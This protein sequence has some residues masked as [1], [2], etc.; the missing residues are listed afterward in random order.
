M[1]DLE[2]RNYRK[3]FHPKGMSIDTIDMK[4]SFKWEKSCEYSFSEKSK[5]ITKILTKYGIE[6]E[7]IVQRLKKCLPKGK[8]EFLSYTDN[9][10][11]A[12]IKEFNL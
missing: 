12:L 1:T 2:S 9:E 3:V 8:N 4:E 5:L 10:Y 7:R 11:K 6:D